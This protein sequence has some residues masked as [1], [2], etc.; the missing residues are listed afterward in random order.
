MAK[1]AISPFVK[2]AYI[3]GR[4][5]LR[6]FTAIPI[7]LKTS[8]GPVTIAPSPIRIAWM[9]PSR[10]VAAVPSRSA[11]SVV[12]AQARCHQAMRAGPP[13]PAPAATASASF[14]SHSS[15]TARTSSRLGSGW[16]GKRTRRIVAASSTGPSSTGSR[17]YDEICMIDRSG[18]Y[19]IRRGRAKRPAS[20]CSAS[21]PR[22]PP[23]SSASAS[24]SVNETFGRTLP[25]APWRKTASP[26]VLRRTTSRSGPGKSAE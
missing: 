24:S 22:C 15:R 14:A 17:R 25:P 9:R 8:P 20:E 26:P 18:R 4:P 6:S 10:N 23:I 5:G 2:P 12:R 11:C 1:Y 13:V 19:T 21:I 3:V 7:S 16:N